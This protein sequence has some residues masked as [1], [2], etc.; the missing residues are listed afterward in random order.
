MKKSIKKITSFAL[1]LTLV[2]SSLVV[3]NNTANAA[4]S[5]ISDG[6]KNIALGKGILYS[7][8][9][10]DG[11]G[12]TADKVTDG[13]LST[14]HFVI[15][16]ANG[17]WGFQGGESFVTIDLGDYYDASTIDEIIIAYKDAAA[18]DTVLNH[19]YYIQYSQDGSNFN[20][21]VTE[22]T[23][24]EFGE[25]NSTTDDVTG[26]T[27]TVRFVKIVYPTT[28]DYGMQ[29]REV[30]V[31][32]Q[33][34]QTATVTK[35]A[36][37]AD[38]T[39]VSESLE[40][41][42]INITAGE[43]QDGYVYN[44]YIGSQKVGDG[45]SAGTDYTY[46]NQPAGDQ[47]VKVTSVKDGIESDGISKTVKIQSM[48]DGVKT[49][50]NVA[51]QKDYILSSGNT[52]EG[53]GSLTDGEFGDYVTSTK[54][55]GA[56]SYFVIDLGNNYKANTIEDVVIWYR[57]TAGGTFP[58]ATDTVIA[59]S[60][61]NATYTEVARLTQATFNATV[62]RAT[63]PFYCDID[64]SGVTNVEAV[65]YIKIDYPTGVNYG[66]Q[67][68]EIEVLD[69]DGDLELAGD[70]VEVSVPAAATAVG[71]NSKITG[72]I[73]AGENQDGYTYIVKIDDVVA[74]TGLSA[75]EYSIGSVA[76][77]EHTVT[78]LSLYE[79]YT[80]TAITAGTVTVAEAPDDASFTVAAGD[81]VKFNTAVG[82]N[83]QII[84]ED[85]NYVYI[86]KNA[87]N[88]EGAFFKTTDIYG[89]YDDAT[90]VPWV[91]EHCTVTGATISF[92]ILGA[93][94][95]NVTSVWVDG[96]KM[97]SG[98]EDVY[99]EGD[100]LHLSQRL[101]ALSGT[102]KEKVTVVTVRGKVDNTFAIKVRKPD[103]P[104]V[105]VAGFQMN[106]NVNGVAQHSPSFRVTSTAPKT[107]DDYAVKTYGTLYGLEMDVT[108]DEANFIIGGTNVHNQVADLGLYDVDE[109]TKG[110]NITFTNNGVTAAAMSAIY[111]IRPYIVLNDGKDTV[112]YGDI[113]TTTINEIAAYLYN[114]TNLGIT[115]A[116]KTYLYNN[117]LNVVAINSNLNAIV[118]AITT[119]LGVT[120]K[121]SQ[122]YYVA[123]GIYKTLR[124][125]NST[126]PRNSKPAFSN[127]VENGW[128]AA[129]MTTT[130]DEFLSTYYYAGPTV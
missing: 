74:A 43:N 31:I 130:I 116:V 32:G 122:Y 107:V 5:D 91:A 120:S 83:G 21:V 37:P 106:T 58:E 121:D 63:A 101:F 97:L 77:G 14:A 68:A 20:T 9:H 66:P 88:G 114:S 124:S 46:T 85:G 56:D 86:S 27:G 61:D 57:S 55:N 115:D 52:T 127:E 71:G 36:D 47:T 41:F 42:K 76:A 93:N 95:G 123:N 54:G 119:E 99:Y 111:V 72:T 92:A 112:V 70:A 84:D 39:A 18:N 49:S 23:V 35:P 113:Q 44:V 98:T 81:W 17:N 78:V 45:V 94:I 7:H 19:S 109:N 126:Y 48:A 82:D 80:S 29:L 26:V 53:N 15:N 6:A 79:G 110:F 33:N 64:V 87:I 128:T 104:V 28:A 38:F 67:A 30:A 69:R 8:M 4:I 11:E 13:S 102:E 65:R 103:T 73:T 50:A 89:L 40:S 108:N 105:E 34:P 22:K 51:Y 3:S 62:N 1:S 12:T 96:T 118:S 117:V 16:D 75:G 10:N 90:N 25:N 59:Y 2:V 60:T 100:Q 129:G 125:Y 24:T